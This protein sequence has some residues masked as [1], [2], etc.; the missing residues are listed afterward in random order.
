MNLS[1]LRIVLALTF[2]CLHSCTPNGNG[3]VMEEILKPEDNADVVE[4]LCDTVNANLFNPFYKPFY[5]GLTM[6]KVF[7]SFNNQDPIISSTASGPGNPLKIDCYPS[8]SDSG[9]GIYYYHF[10]DFEKGEFGTVHIKVSLWGDGFWMGDTTQRINSIFIR[11]RCEPFDQLLPLGR[12]GSIMLLDREMEKIDTNLFSYS[13][14]DYRF[15]YL[16][17]NDRIDAVLIERIYCK[18]HITEPAEIQGYY[19]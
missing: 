10:M 16:T 2:V 8:Y 11:G 14:D 13:E 3:S 1:F 18:N 9:T 6:T 19:K 12:E 15:W 5:S 4:E 7:E 17:K